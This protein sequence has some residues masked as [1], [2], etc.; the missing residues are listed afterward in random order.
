MGRTERLSSRG[1]SWLSVLLPALAALWGS[2]WGC[3]GIVEDSRH[4]A[5]G[6]ETIGGGTGGSAPGIVTTPPIASCGNG[7]IDPGEQCDGNTFPLGLDTCSAATMG[8][9]T[10]WALS[11]TGSCTLSFAGCFTLGSGGRPQTGAGGAPIGGSFGQGGFAGSMGF[12]SSPADACYARG[13]VPDSS[14]SE[15]CSQGV[16]A[17]N[18]CINKRAAITC[19]DKCACSVC[20]SLYD[21]CMTD[22]ACRWLIACAEQYQ[23]YSVASCGAYCA[24]LIKTAGGP[25]TSSAALLDSTLACLSGSNCPLSCP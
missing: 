3:G 17:A 4:G 20:A 7:V 22:G 6:G 10:S 11:C 9:S 16:D 15:N 8:K 19:I 5:D 12:P 2:E 24:D 18:V 13:G 25:G 14:S 1:R 21:H 23:C